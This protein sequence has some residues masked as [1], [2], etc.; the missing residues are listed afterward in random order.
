MK[1]LPAR[2]RT[3]PLRH[4]DGSKIRDLTDH[5]QLITTILYFDPTIK[6]VR[7]VN[8]G[9]KWVT[10]KHGSKNPGAHPAGKG[11]ERFSKVKTW[12]L[13]GGN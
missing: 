6:R 11:S 4:M 3:L 1:D 7:R 5:P 10:L 12:D 8:F 9:F 2:E 13:R